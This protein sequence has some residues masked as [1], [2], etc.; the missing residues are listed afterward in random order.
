[1]S[2]IIFLQLLFPNF[3]T[4]SEA[5]FIT[6][7]RIPEEQKIEI[8]QTGFQLKGYSINYERIR[9]TKFYQQFKE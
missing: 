5:N 7:G 3:Q 1:M 4:L 9:C 6:L 8:I 2:Y